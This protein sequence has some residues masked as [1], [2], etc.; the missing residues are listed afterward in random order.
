MLSHARGCQQ[1]PQTII[2]VAR[3]WI[4]VLKCYLRSGVECGGTTLPPRATLA[5]MAGEVS[6]W[7]MDDLKKPPDLEGDRGGMMMMAMWRY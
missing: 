7:M 1:C 6:G 5:T 2:L 4:D 3:T